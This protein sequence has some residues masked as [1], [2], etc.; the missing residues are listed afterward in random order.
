MP[1]T[2]VAADSR[3]SPPNACL[4]CVFQSVESEANETAKNVRFKQMLENF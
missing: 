1:I 4:T 3:F 2:S